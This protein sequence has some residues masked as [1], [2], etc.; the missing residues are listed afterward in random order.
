MVIGAVCG[1]QNC[2]LKKWCLGNSQDKVTQQAVKSGQ[3]SDLRLNC[4]D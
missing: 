4:L 3:Y 1:Q 2:L